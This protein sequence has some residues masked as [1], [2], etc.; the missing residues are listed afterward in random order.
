MFIHIDYT[1]VH[2][3]TFN[4]YQPII[5]AEV[6]IFSASKHQQ[7]TDLHETLLKLT[8]QFPI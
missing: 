2:T 1:I 4:K 7:N 8:E 3:T 6:P 5:D